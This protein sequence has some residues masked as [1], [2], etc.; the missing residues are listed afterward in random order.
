MCTSDMH[1][2]TQLQLFVPENHLK[3]S[4]WDQ[5]F[6]HIPK[7][8]G[9]YVFY[10]QEGQVLY[11][12]KSKSLKQRLSSYRSDLKGVKSSKT[13]RL[14]T[15]IHRI[16][17]KVLASELHA[18]LEEDRLIK[19]LKPHYNRVNAQSD[20]Y[21]FIHFQPK[22]SPNKFQI[23]IGMQA[24]QSARSYG[25]YK[26][27]LA[28]RR[29]FGALLRLTFLS[30]SV[31]MNS[32]YFPIY[33]L[34]KLAPLR[35]DHFVRKHTYNRIND[36]LMGKSF[37]FLRQ[38][39]QKTLKWYHQIGKNERTLIEQDI[40][41]LYTF[42]YRSCLPLS[43]LNTKKAFTPKNELDQLLIRWGRIRKD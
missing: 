25:A 39:E 33:L 41:I 43:V 19:A 29:A 16:K 34:R 11:V 17:F 8:A 14:I 37:R 2:S 4:E 36:L 27:H 23:S 18:L 42:F 15:K 28:V 32:F 13:R 26:G 7:K 10:D 31:A 22:S 3:D 38:I 21:Y 35:V 5:F 12:G 40:G 9:V 20:T 1:K 24:R 30:E 6:K